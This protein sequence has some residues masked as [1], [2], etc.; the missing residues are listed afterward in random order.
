MP[1]LY[2]S[3]SELVLFSLSPSKAQTPRWLL[4]RFIAEEEKV[5]FPVAIKFFI[6]FIKFLIKH[7]NN[8]S[9]KSER[10]RHSSMLADAFIRATSIKFIFQARLYLEFKKC[11][12]PVRKGG[13]SCESLALDRSQRCLQII[14]FTTLLQRSVSQSFFGYRPFFWQTNF[15]RPPTMPSTRINT[16]FSYC[17]FWMFEND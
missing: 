16:L 6:K 15:Y 8:S 13:I 7:R 17:I 3:G 14:C 2:K 12:L 10:C 4:L 9:L 5:G 1:G 11:A